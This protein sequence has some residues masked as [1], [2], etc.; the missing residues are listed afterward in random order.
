M[1]TLPP[2][3]RLAALAAGLTLAQASPSGQPPAPPAGQAGARHLR[4]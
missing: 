3:R 2:G 1:M 4:D